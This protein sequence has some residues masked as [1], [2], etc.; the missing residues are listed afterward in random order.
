MS[1]DIHIP[2]NVP[3]PIADMLHNL[4]QTPSPEANAVAKGIAA[5]FEDEDPTKP[6]DFAMRAADN[7]EDWARAARTVIYNRGMGYGYDSE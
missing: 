3:E 7:I 4:A 1:T 6:Y 5:A 2:E